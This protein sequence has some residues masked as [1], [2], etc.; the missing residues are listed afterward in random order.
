MRT[1]CALP[2]GFDRLDLSQLGRGR[3]IRDIDDAHPAVVGEVGLIS[4]DVHAVSDPDTGAIPKNA[5]PR[6]AKTV[7]SKQVKRAT[8]KT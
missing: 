2:C 6:K 1:G 7:P 3:R 5:L 8:L 4:V